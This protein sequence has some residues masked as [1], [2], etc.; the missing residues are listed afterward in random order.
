MRRATRAL[1]LIAGAAGLAAVGVFAWRHAAEL[2]RWRATPAATGA[3]L[4]ALA[5]YQLAL[6]GA[7]GAWHVLLRAVGEPS[8]LGQAVRI[9]LLS[10]LGKYLPGNVGHLLGRVALASRQG[11]HAAPVL[12][13]IAVET[14]C[15]ILA[16]AACALALLPA[17]SGLPALAR[18]LAAAAA[19][20]LGA[21]T[22]RRLLARPAVRRRLGAAAGDAPRLPGAGAWLLCLIANGVNFTLFAG[23]GLLLARSQLRAGPAPLPQLVGA[24]AAGWVSG[25]VTPGAPA[26]LGVREAVLSAALVPIWGPGPAVALPLVYR[27]FTLLGDAVAFVIG[28]LLPC[29][30]AAAGENHV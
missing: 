4:A 23:A 7:A 5:L 19:L 16:G 20:V 14:A 18:I 13:T 2:P 8:R 28:W 12:I 11:L 26:G 25:F 17:G 3:L 9:L 15:A 30:A 27:L 21:I 1:G 10:Q 22:A 29:P 6:L 24:F